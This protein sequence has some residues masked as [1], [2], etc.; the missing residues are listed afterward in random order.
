M[1][2]KALTLSI[3]ICCL[4]IIGSAGDGEVPYPLAKA[5]V[6]DWLLYE[7]QGGMQQKQTVLAV[8]EEA[9][10]VK[11]DTIMNGSTI[12]SME[13]DYPLKADTSAGM[14]DAVDAPKPKISEATLTVK[15][16]DLK[17]QVVEA[18]TQGMTTKS[19][20]CDGVPITG[21]A[22][23]EVAGSVAMTLVDFGQFHH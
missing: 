10:K 12:N 3:V 5:E 23:S 1:R 11:I 15:G 21:V 4:A 8:S 9:V 20:M 19:W 14:Q 2:E 6:G 16:K 18:E 7:M 13:M 22:K 17:C